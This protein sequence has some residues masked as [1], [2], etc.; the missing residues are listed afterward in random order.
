MDQT[1]FNGFSF[2][3][4]KMDTILEKWDILARIL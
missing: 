2:I 4:P 3:N 1:A